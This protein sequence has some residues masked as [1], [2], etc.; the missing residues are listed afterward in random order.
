MGQAHRLTTELNEHA[1]KSAPVRLTVGRITGAHGLG[2][3]LRVRPGDPDSDTLQIVTRVYLE[4]DGATHEYA[5]LDARRINRTTIRIVLDGVQG[6]ECA[7]QLRGA[8]LMVA[9]ADLPPAGPGEFYYYQLIG[10]EVVTTL[11]RRLGTVEEVFSGGANDVLVVRENE[12]EILIPVIEDVVKAMD[13]EGR[14]VTV[15]A[16]P[17]LID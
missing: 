16:V 17:G 4:Q 9:V 12:A 14:K 3:A 8:T 10:C 6:V 11:G 7:E 1:P 2:G 5:L 15:Q 13:L